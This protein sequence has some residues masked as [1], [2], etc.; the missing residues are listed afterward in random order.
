[1]ISGFCRIDERRFLAV[2]HNSESKLGSPRCRDCCNG[3]LHLLDPRWQAHR[4]SARPVDKYPD[5]YSVRWSQCRS[6]RSNIRIVEDAVRRERWH[7]HPSRIYSLQ[8]DFWSPNQPM[9]V[10]LQ[11]LLLP[12]RKLSYWK[13]RDLHF[14]SSSISKKKHVS[15]NNQDTFASDFDLPRRW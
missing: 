11:V 12:R 2:G 8:L 9:L 4:K 10:L 7:F 1:M 6:R 15:A 3:L 5:R 14:G 13:R